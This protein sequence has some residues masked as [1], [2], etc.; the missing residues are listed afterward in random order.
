VLRK[1]PFPAYPLAP[2]LGSDLAGSS[3]PTC[4]HGVTIQQTV[5][6]NTRVLEGPSHHFLNKGEHFQAAC[7]HTKFR[8]SASKKIS[9][10][11]AFKATLGESFNSGKQ[12]TEIVKS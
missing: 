10:D 1:V 9:R 2:A 5:G 7:L 4:P 12:R 11:I 6:R 8:M 3:H